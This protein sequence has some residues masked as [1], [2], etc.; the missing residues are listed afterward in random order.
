VSTEWDN[1]KNLLK[2]PSEGEPVFPWHE[3]EGRV[4]RSNFFKFSM[5]T[6]N[7]YYLSLILTF[8]MAGGFAAYKAIDFSK[9]MVDKNKTIEQKERNE[10]IIMHTLDSLDQIVKKNDSLAV[11]EN[12]DN[13]KIIQA[14]T[15]KQPDQ[16]PDTVTNIVVKKTVVKK[17]LIVKKPQIKDTVI[18]RK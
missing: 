3:L 17:Q 15:I 11:S 8:A 10:K 4:K 14:R 6:F 18:I 1:I 5:M 12:K 9:K 7:V 13:Q 16:P 2:S